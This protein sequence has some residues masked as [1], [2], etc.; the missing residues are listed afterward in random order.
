M[1]SVVWSPRGTYFAVSADTKVHVFS[2]DIAGIISTVQ[3]N[4]RITC[5][6]FIEVCS[7]FSLIG[8]VSLPNNKIAVFYFRDLSKI[9]DKVA[10]FLEG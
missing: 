10:E 3:C 4:S 1:D 5:V 6:T 8:T 9:S 2:A 7:I